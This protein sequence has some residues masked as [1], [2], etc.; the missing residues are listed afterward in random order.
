MRPSTIARNYAEAL[1]TAGERSGDSSRFADL[2]EGVGGAMEA[3]ERIRLTLE[4]P[5]F[6]KP[7]KQA[8]LTK[9]LTGKAPPAFIAFLG[10]VIK[11]NRQSL[12][13]T[14][15]R[16]Y[17]S[18]VD[19]KFN[20][21]HAGVTVARK[22]DAELQQLIKERLSQYMAKDVIP[23][24]REDPAILGGVI[25]RVGDRILDGSLRRKMVALRRQMLRG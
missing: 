3:D 23:H 16:E 22:P 21:V 15:A 9:A 18:L 20:R 8:L 17:L 11:R 1:F 13:P 25:V 4:S 24:F 10:A 6:P 12:L 7:V 19:T 14:I 5:R 2:I